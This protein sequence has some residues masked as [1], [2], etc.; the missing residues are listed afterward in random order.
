MASSPADL[1]EDWLHVSSF[2][3]EVDASLGMW[4]TE[5]HGVALTEYRALRCLSAVPE[6]ELRIT[7]LA[8]RIGLNQSSVTRLLGRLEAKR[9]TRRDTCY[10]DGRGVYAVI[11][12]QGEALLG[13]AREPFQGQIQQ[14][15]DQT[16]EH[17][18]AGGTLAA[19]RALDRVGARMRP[20]AEAG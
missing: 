7:E 17:G 15:L 8:R 16:R 4:L 5:H 14:L 1:V 3:A 11:T 2:V 18:R 13:E 9:L 19:A 6:K 20:P 12:E 10:E